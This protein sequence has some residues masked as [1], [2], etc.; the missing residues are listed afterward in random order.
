MSSTL[1]LRGAGHIRGYLGGKSLNRSQITSS[2]LIFYLRGYISVLQYTS[3][4]LNYP[5]L[6]DYHNSRCQSFSINTDTRAG[7]DTLQPDSG[8]NFYE[9]L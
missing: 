3:K 1:P 2:Y 6:P 5:V 7:R 8:V 4:V 9:K